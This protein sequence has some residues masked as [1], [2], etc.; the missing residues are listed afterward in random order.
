MKNFH[1]QKFEEIRM[2]SNETLSIYCMRLENIVC[3]AYPR[4]HKRQSRAL[5]E[6]MRMTAPASFI[7]LLDDLKEVKRLTKMG[8]SVS[9]ADIVERAAEEDMKKKRQRY[10][11][12]QCNRV[13]E[14]VLQS[15]HD[16]ERRLPVVQ[17]S[18]YSGDLSKVC[19]PQCEGGVL[20][21][22]QQCVEVEY[23][24]CCS[25][26]MKRGHTDIDCRKRLRQCLLCGSSQHWLRQ[27][28]K[29]M[30]EYGQ[31]NV[32]RTLLNVNAPIFRPKNVI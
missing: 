25:W 21:Q 12:G 11:G 14:N 22:A 31:S 23:Q 20:P 9:W 7:A 4:C 18:D 1:R 16:D 15:H 3:K 27:C 10:A 26:C 2:R 8:K 28:D 24:G 5:K 32:N 13:C 17:P 6:K 29:Y 30:P 19:I